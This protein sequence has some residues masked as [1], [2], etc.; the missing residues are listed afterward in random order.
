M[1]RKKK[2]EREKKD[3]SRERLIAAKL[4]MKEQEE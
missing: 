2:K 3:A 1:D 4:K